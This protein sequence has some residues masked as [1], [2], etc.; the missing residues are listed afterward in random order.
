MKAINYILFTL[1]TAIGIVGMDAVDNAHRMSSFDQTEQLKTP[2]GFSLH[3]KKR[4]RIKC[5][6][7][8]EQD[9]DT[10]LLKFKNSDAN[11]NLLA[12]NIAFTYG[13]EQSAHDQ[14]SK[15]VTR[16][17]FKYYHQLKLFG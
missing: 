6:I 3:N 15:R 8:K 5:L 2:Q 14:S 12:I 13:L 11:N 1:F 4:L 17:L 16:H 9:A 7:E 10:S